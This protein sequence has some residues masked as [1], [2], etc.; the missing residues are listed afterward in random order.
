MNFQLLTPQ[1]SP[2]SLP[3]SY[4]NSSIRYSTVNQ[5][6]TVHSD[7]NIGGKKWASVT[8]I[9]Y[10]NFS[11]LRMGENGKHDYTKPFVVQRMDNEDS[12]LTQTDPYLQNPSG[13]SQINVLQKVLFK[14]NK[15][16]N[17]TYRFNYS[18]TS[19]YSRYDRLIQTSKG[20][21]KYAQFD[22]GPQKWL[23]NN[24]KL[25]STPKDAKLYTQ[26]NTYVAHQYFEE[27]R[28]S[29]KLN[30]TEQQTRTEKVNAYSINSDFYKVVNHK[31]TINYGVESVINFIESNG[32]DKN[33]QLNTSTT[34]AARYPQSTWSS[35]AL[36]L[37][38]KYQLSP[39]SL[40]KTGVRYNHFLLKADFDT[41]FYPF[42][43][44]SVTSS[45]HGLSGNVGWLYSMN[46]KTSLSLSASNGFRSPNV[47]D[48]GKVFDSEPGNV[49]VPNTQLMSENAYSTELGVSK[50][51]GKSIT[52]D[53]ATYYTYL[54]NALVRRDFTFNG[55]DSILYDGSKSKVQA[56]QNAAFAYVYGFQGSATIKL[57]FHFKISSQ[58][59]YQK[60]E[61]ELDDGSLSALR[62]AA[63][64]Y[65]TTHLRY[66]H[67]KLK[68]D[69]Y[70]VYSGAKMANEMPQ[71]E[72]EKD[73]LY[74]K[75][76]NNE[77]YSPSWTT[78][79]IKAQ[80]HFHKYFKLSAGVEN[81]TDL[82]YLPYSSGL[83]AGGRNYV[84]TIASHF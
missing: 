25:T 22:Y 48:L 68:A 33:I 11:D 8:S 14:P 77:P 46:K 55:N 32:I 36:Y 65:G 19:N 63:P 71:S 42:S 2:D 72:I 53:A 56:I 3:L 24:V 10:T 74:A 21:P 64:V 80:Y 16:F 66:E 84:I 34:G 23:V 60:G 5:E 58:I 79:N 12:V 1:S 6:K 62:H 20:L 73:Y 9:S 49:V 41:T 47:D 44:T 81:I 67:D 39:K 82:Q 18:N 26:M 59:T 40:I 37:T 76:S 30:S 4:G 57:P 78:F 43:F 13:Y 75:N 69:F 61:E 83:V 28:I 52:I 35:N 17:V 7:F 54:K 45:N 50:Q 29:R 27:S 31:N 70:V 38:N 15:H 51:I